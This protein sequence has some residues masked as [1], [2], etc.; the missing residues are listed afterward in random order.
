VLFRSNRRRKEKGKKVAD[1]AI[2]KKWK[3]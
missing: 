3:K 2:G 1:L